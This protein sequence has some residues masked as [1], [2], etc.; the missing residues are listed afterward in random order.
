MCI[1]RE[2]Y[3]P[4]SAV[5]AHLWHTRMSR[6]PETDR[7]SAGQHAAGKPVRLTPSDHSAGGTDS[8]IRC[9]QLAQIDAHSMRAQ[10][11]MIRAFV[12]S[13]AAKALP[14]IGISGPFRAIR[15]L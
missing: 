3:L 8:T 7:M 5:V 14:G 4:V 10:H 2:C 12:P 11:G 6:H 15:S 13:S 1:P 9:F